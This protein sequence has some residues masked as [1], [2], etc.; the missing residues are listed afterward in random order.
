M[1]GV[2]PDEGCRRRLPQWMQGVSA[3]ELVTKNDNVEENGMIHE[4][5]FMPRLRK[6]LLVH[7]KEK[8]LESSLC[9]AKC[10]PKRRKRNSKQRDADCDSNISETLPDKENNRFGRKVSVAR[11]KRK[12]TISKFGRSEEL[13][14]QPPDVDDVDLSVEDL[15]I[16]AEE[17]ISFFF[18]VKEFLH[19]CS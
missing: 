9:H 13:E 3:T 18:T 4:E 16:I 14:V 8:L 17:V 2:V 12:T 15:M 5:G 11:K 19:R 10:D 6:E 7:K 1:G